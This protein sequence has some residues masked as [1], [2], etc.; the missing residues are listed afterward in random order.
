MIDAP[1]KRI[2]AA[3]LAYEREGE[4]LPSRKQV[5]LRVKMTPYGAMFGHHIG[6]LMRANLIE[7]P[8]GQLALTDSGRKIAEK[9]P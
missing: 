6:L 7:Y 3:L 9:L 4:P 1:R 8:L 2:L 5:A